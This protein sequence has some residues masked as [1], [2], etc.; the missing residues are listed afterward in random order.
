MAQPPERTVYCEDAVAWLE[1]SPVLTGCSVVVN[2]LCGQ[3]S[4][5]ATANAFGLSSIGIELSR[6]C[7][8]MAR[9]LQADIDQKKW[10][11]G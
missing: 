5:L 10:R 2:P 11:L 8:E 7:A 3:G 9:S 1:K 6:K 4:M